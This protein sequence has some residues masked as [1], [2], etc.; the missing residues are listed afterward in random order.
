MS[1]PELLDY[2]PT[3]P[4]LIDHCVSAFADRDF[5]VSPQARYTYRDVDDMSRQ[6]AGRLLAGGVGKGTRVGLL[7]SQNQDWIAAYWAVTRIGAVAVTISTYAQ[8]AELLALLRH[9]DIHLLV[10]S[11]HI[12]G[13]N[14][15]PQLEKAIPGLAGTQGPALHQTA[16]PYLRHIW[17][18]GAS[19]RPWATPVDWTGGTAVIPADLLSAIQTEVSPADPLVIIYTS[20]TSADPK[21]VILTHGAVV[22]H[23]ENLHQLGLIV[24]GDRVYAGMP[25]F[26]VGGLSFTLTTAMHAGATLLVQEPFEPGAALELMERERATNLTGWQ[27]L[28]RLLLD[29]P[30]RPS[31]DLSAMVRGPLAAALRQGTALVSMGMTETSASHSVGLPGQ[32]PSPADLP[33]VAGYAVPGLSRRIVDPGSGAVLPSMAHG[34]IC[35]RGYSLLAGMVKK[36]HH[37]VFDA[38]GWYHTGDGG[39]LT[40]DGLLVFTGRLTEMIKTK[41]MN[42][43]PAEVETALLAHPQ[44][45]EAYVFGVPDPDLGERVIAA[46]VLISGEG[47]SDPEPHLRT[48]CDWLKG[49]LASY[50]IP[51]EL[52]RVDAE[53][54]PLLASRKVDK[55]ALARLAL[56]RLPA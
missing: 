25:F 38:D 37:E 17:V 22:R 26:W 36:E 9:S 45:S 48:I 2:P 56:Q 1:V 30:T 29:H 10:L 19:G 49:R 42:V 44:V 18:L 6:L 32:T 40:A 34:E 14:Q 54:V 31:R 12:R 20:G 50:K 8:P 51:T 21:G 39:Y 28:V 52:V 55:R 3:L 47:P 5:V 7:M 23:G 35:V 43:A 13:K 24:D 46:V 15:L 27:T 16:T 33:G 53:E 4:R 41:G 11:G